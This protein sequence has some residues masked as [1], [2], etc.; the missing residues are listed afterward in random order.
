MPLVRDPLQRQLDRSYI[1]AVA[2]L[3]DRF[4]VLTN[5]EHSG[6]RGVKR[7]V[8]QA[9][10]SAA[11][12]ASSGLYLPGLAAGGVQLQDRHGQLSHPG[13]SEAELAFLAAVPEQLRQRLSPLLA[14]ALPQTT[15]EQRQQLLDR[16]I[17]D[18]AVSPTANLNGVFELLGDLPEAIAWL[19]HQCLAVL[20]ELL[21]LAETQ[22]LAG[23]FFVHLA[24]NLGSEQGREQL[25]PARSGQHGTTDFQ[26][27]LRG[28]IK[29]AGL[30]VLINRQIQART[31]V[32]PL[33]ESFNVRTAPAQLSELLQLCRERIP[34]EQMPTLVGV[35]DTITSEASADGSGWRRGGSDRGFLTLVQEIGRTFGRPN[36]VVLVDSSQGELDRP[37]LQNPA[38]TGLS[39][40]E[41]PLQ[42]NVLVPGG[43]P[44]YR[45]W[46][47]QLSR[48]LI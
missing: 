19:Q 17:L 22:G 18:N 1:E 11:A 35:G 43:P 2:R 21:A 39:D 8:E 46:F 15:A 40:P 48:S 31:G 36:R 12:A 9:I 44:Q 30:L 13:V 25:K 20:E 5:G 24:P 4:R 3:G 33:G 42:I 6:S 32:A 28:A 16:L 45:Q 27:M 47:E 14:E 29:E 7:L 37:S 23:S 41:D 38:L 26:F 34:A 10:G